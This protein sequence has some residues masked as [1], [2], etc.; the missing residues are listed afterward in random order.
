MYNEYNRYSYIIFISG[1]TRDDA[2]GATA[3]PPH[4][5]LKKIKNYFNG[6]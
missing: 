3:G 1:V 2:E 6:L 5:M 4:E